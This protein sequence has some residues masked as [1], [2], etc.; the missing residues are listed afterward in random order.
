MSKRRGKLVQSARRSSGDAQATDSKR[1]L[2]W[3]TI[4]A[5]CILAA[6]GAVVVLGMTRNAKKPLVDTS[7]SKTEFPKSGVTQFRQPRSLA[8]LVSLPSEKLELVD[9]GVMN[10]LCA[11]GLPGSENLNVEKESATLDEWAELV[12][13]LTKEQHFL[14]ERAPADYENSENNFK[15]FMLVEVLQT[16]CGIHYNP[17]WLYIST[18]K[19]VPRREGYAPYRDCRNIFINGLIEQRL[20]T[21]ANMA[22]L[23]VAVARRIG[24]PVYLVRSKSHF[25]ARWDDG[26]ERFNCEGTN[27]GMVEP[28]RRTDEHYKKWMGGLT[29]E[30]LQDGYYLKNMTPAALLA[31]FVFMRGDALRMHGFGTPALECFVESY[32]RAP[33]FNE[34][35]QRMVESLKLVDSQ[36]QKFHQNP[37][38]GFAANSPTEQ[39]AQADAVSIHFEQ[40]RT[41]ERLKSQ[42]TELQPK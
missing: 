24:Y 34:Y 5:I 37:P 1:R 11:E 10:L 16:R 3:G 41:L 31:E 42:L 33:Q 18:N 19:N 2:H 26:K 32:S 6:V 22:A 40:I 17:D 12:K 9:F 39:L 15:M 4:A 23:Y 30:E 7:T 28:Y 14:F 27:R 13:R 36:L 35:K 21:C 8:E 29:N 25:F 20:G 38:I